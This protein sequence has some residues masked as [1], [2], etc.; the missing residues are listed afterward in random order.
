MEGQINLAA[1]T[2]SVSLGVTRGFVGLLDVLGFSNLVSGDA[3]G[4]RL[5]E[6]KYV[7]VEARATAPW[8]SVRHAVAKAYPKMPDTMP[9][10]GPSITPPSRASRPSSRPGHDGRQPSV[11]YTA[12]HIMARRRAWPTR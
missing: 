11:I 1:G 5:Q 4:A 3:A 2:P 12:R 6:P 7:G 9:T 8:A 10:P